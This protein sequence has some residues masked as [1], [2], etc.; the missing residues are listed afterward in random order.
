MCNT[1]EM[2][3]LDPFDPAVTMTLKLL[4][5]ERLFWALEPVLSLASFRMRLTWFSNVCLRVFPGVGS[6]SLLCAFL[7][8]SITSLCR[9]TLWCSVLYSELDLV[10]PF[11]YRIKFYSKHIIGKVFSRVMYWMHINRT[12]KH[13]NSFQAA[14][15]TKLCLWLIY[16]YKVMNTNFFYGVLQKQLFK[17]Y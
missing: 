12:Y 4:K 1:C 2:L 11:Y 15:I 6:K 16:K 17:V 8:T 3:I 5:S 7:M 9:G 13:P 14:H 10:S